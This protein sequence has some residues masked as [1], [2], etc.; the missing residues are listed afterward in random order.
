MVKILIPTDVYHAQFVLSRYLQITSGDAS[1]SLKR[2][3]TGSNG[4]KKGSAQN[5]RGM[6]NARRNH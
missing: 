3:E 6:F 5:F 1:S 2:R 4:L